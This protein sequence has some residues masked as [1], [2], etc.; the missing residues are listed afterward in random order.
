MDID[1]FGLTVGAPLA[2][3]VLEISHQFLAL[4]ASRDDRLISAEEVD[5][6]VVDVTK[7]CVAIDV[8]TA[9]SR[10]A[11]CLQAVVHLAQQIAH[12]GRTDLVTLLCQLPDEIT[13][14]PARPQQRSHRIA[15]CRRLNQSLEILQQSGI[16]RRFLLASTTGSADTPG[17]RGHIIVNIRKPLINGG[18]SQTRDPGHQTNAATP[19]RSGFHSDKPAPALLI[20]N[21]SNLPVSLAYGSSLRSANHAATLRRQIP[22]CES[23]SCHSARPVATLTHLFTDEPLAARLI[24]VLDGPLLNRAGSV[25]WEGANSIYSPLLVPIN[26]IHAPLHAIV[27]WAEC[28]IKDMAK[29]ENKNAD[30]FHIKEVRPGLNELH[31]YLVDLWR[32]V[33]GMTATNV[34]TRSPL[35]PFLQVAVRTITRVSVGPDTAKN[36][37][38]KDMRIVAR[39]SSIMGG[40]FGR[41]DDQV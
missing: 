30:R 10:L 23:L 38:R 16:F 2:A 18:T 15:A 24:T 12:N 14:A 32:F 33:T 13:Q 36:W 27:R 11:V 8:P 19:E 40:F 39:H 28:G 5:R 31:L 29:N 7:L 26:S 21:R 35:I 9:F 4:G 1:E 6:L 25:E 20:Q 22:H 17:C 3:V 41:P 37:A 34:E